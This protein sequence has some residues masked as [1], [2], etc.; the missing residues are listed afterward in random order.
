MSPHGPTT[1]TV[2]EALRRQREGARLWDLRSDAERASGV[3]SGAEAVVVDAATDDALHQRAGLD[4]ALLLICAAG[5]RSRRAAERLRAIGYRDVA[6]VEGGVAAWRAAG[7]PIDVVPPWPDAPPDAGERYARHLRLDGVGVAGQARLARSR[8]LLIGAGG[9]GSPV[10]L[11]LAAAGVGHLRIADDDLVDRSNLQRQV[12]HDDA[13]VGRPKAD[14]ARERLMALNPGIDVDVRC[15]RL[16]ATNV[17]ALVDG[18]DVVVDGSD[19]F[20]TRYLANAACVRHGL[21]LVYGAVERFHGQAAVFANAAVTPEARR[22]PCYQCLFPEPPGPGEAPDCA[23]AGVL[24]V[25]P[26]LVGMVQAT[27]TLKLLLGLGSPLAGRLL[28]IDALGMRFRES[29][30]EHDPDCPTCGPSAH[31]TG[32]A[33]LARWC[34]AG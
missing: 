3:P 18:V 8:V 21:P 27:E 32:Y 6:S 16:A 17:E 1:A 20:P 14:S 22:A 5:V 23:A 34:A 33:D 7:L 31:F 4:D 19:N 15:E 12:L 2:H 11:Y 25:L 30:F 24:G 13:A 29:A 26:G 10:A 9:L 28:R